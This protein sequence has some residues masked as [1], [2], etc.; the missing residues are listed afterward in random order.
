MIHGYIGDLVQVLGQEVSLIHV[1]GADGVEGHA[2]GV[3]QGQHGGEVYG[4]GAWLVHGQCIGG[5]VL[6]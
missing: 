1:Q 4:H 5:G 3:V 2:V 6:G